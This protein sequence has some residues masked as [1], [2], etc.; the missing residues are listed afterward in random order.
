MGNSPE[1][2]VLQ[3]SSEFRGAVRAGETAIFR[4]HSFPYSLASVPRS[5][6]ET[7][8][9]NFHTS[10]KA[11]RDRRCL[12]TREIVDGKLGEYRWKTYKEVY[13]LAERLMRGIVANNLAE[14]NDQGLRIIGI[15]SINREE[16]VI[17]DLACT[18]ADITNVPLYSSYGF[19]A[20][21]EIIDLTGLRSIIC[22]AD[23]LKL[24][25]RMRE[26]FG[27]ALLKN[28]ILLD[29]IDEDLRQQA[30][31][32]NLTLIDYKSLFEYPEAI[33][34]NPPKPT[35][36]FTVCFTSGATGSCK[37]AVVTHS[38]IMGAIAGSEAMGFPFQADDV[39]IS[40]LPLAHMMERVAVHVM[41]TEGASIGFYSGSVK[42]LK[43]D[44]EVLQPTIF[45]S[46]PRIFNMFYTTIRHRL[47]SLPYARRQLV[48]QALS[49]KLSAYNE[50][51]ALTSSV[52]DSLVFQKIKSTVGGRVRLMISGSAP[53]SGEVLRFLR[54]CFCCPIIEG[55]GQT[56]SCAAS[57]LT[58]PDDYE[59]G[60]IGGPVPSIE[61]KIIDVPEMNYF[62]SGADEL[63]TF[64]PRGELCLRG[65]PVVKSY[66]KL[67]EA[68]EN[69]IDSDGWLHTGDIVMLLPGGAVKVIDRVKYIFKL[70]QGEYIAPERLESIYSE[71]QFIETIMVYG[72]SYKD[73]LA[74]IVYINEEFVR[75]E[76]CRERQIPSKTPIELL[77][78]NED[79]IDD[80]LLDLGTIA[81]KE[82]LVGYEFVKKVWL[83]P[84]PFPTEVFT[85]TQKLKRHEAKRHFQ[86]AIITELESSS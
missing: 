77:C 23:K 81:R 31:G 51:G 43:D 47:D 66:Y 64:F 80:V 37:G 65:T 32:L 82:H 49:S 13:D 34:H 74:A 63:G 9:E 85:A 73:F 8:Y 46:V 6:A 52:W 68:T 11:F 83:T 24:L 62:T 48:N 59:V 17:S 40:Y 14:E 28:V 5:S 30:E 7:I 71:S 57:F 10:V 21:G 53:I 25:I 76:W 19:E 84:K 36:V 38:N 75:S 67:P 18:L 16:W 12:G 35:S 45:I 26:T 44:M 15:F 2:Q 41:L 27:V 69:L 20:V 56:E 58:K 70:A 4:N 55:Y 39:H 3:Y 42:N 61:F 86:A 78:A 50:T 22:G 72:D 60:R 1:R 33:E 29:D 54:I 79:L